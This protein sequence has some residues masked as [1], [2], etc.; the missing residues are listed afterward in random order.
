ME[1]AKQLLD[2]HEG[3]VSE[4]AQAVGP[5]LSVSFSMILV[6]H[7]RDSRLQSIGNREVHARCKSS[8]V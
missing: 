6:D 7:N 8:R 2:G 3:S 1:R 4:V 5:V